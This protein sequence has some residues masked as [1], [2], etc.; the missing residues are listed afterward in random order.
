MPNFKVRL[1]RL[2][3]QAVLT[4]QDVGDQIGVSKVA[5]SGYENGIRTPEIETLI[6]IAELFETSIDYLVGYLRL[7]PVL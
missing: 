1:K 2:R 6:K 5:V 4:Q 3:K 7:T